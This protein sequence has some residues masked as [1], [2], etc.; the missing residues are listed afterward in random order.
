MPPATIEHILMGK[1][2]NAAGTL[3]TLPELHRVFDHLT[4]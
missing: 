1:L 2:N 4:T 3:A